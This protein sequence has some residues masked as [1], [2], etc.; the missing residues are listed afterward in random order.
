[1][2]IRGKWDHSSV[3]LVSTA[4]ASQVELRA[5]PA[6]VEVY[7]LNE[8]SDLAGEAITDL[9]GYALER[10]RGDTEFVLYRAR[11]DA[12]TRHILVLAPASE[13]PSYSTLK[14]IE[15]EYALRTELDPAWAVL[16]FAL[17]RD[18]GR[19]LLA[20]KD[21]GG[22]PLDRL[23]ERP[24]ELKQ[25]LRV[26]IALAA[27]LSRLH[28]RGI[29]HKDIKPANVMVS[30]ASDE[31]WLTGFGI[32]TDSSRE[33]QA[34][35]P[36]Q[37]IAGT[38]AYMA[39]EQTGRMNRSIDS[40]SDLY[41]LGVT[42]YQMLT[43][44]LPFTASDPVEWVYCHIARQPSPPEERRKDV[45][46]ALSAIV[47]K[48]LA[49]S[50]EERYQT[51]A[52]LQ[53]DLKRC[54][55]DLER[56]GRIEPFVTGARDVS[57]R[58]TIPEEVYGRE[59]ETTA[60]LDA[61]DRV[62][63]SGA[64]ELVLVSGHSG[65]GKSSIVNELHKAIV[66][67]RGIF[68]SGKFDQYKRDIPY[69]TLALAFQTLIRQI[70]SR[71]E[72]EVGRRRDAL[73]DAIDPNGQL[74]V[75][76][77]P[78]LELIIGKQAPVPELSAQD[79]EN[80]FQWVFRAFVGV[81][82]RKEHPLAL[83]LDDLQW[84]DAATLNLIEHLIIHPDVRHLLLIGAYR[85]NEV[86]ASHPLMLMLD[87]LRK[88][89]AAVR[90][91]VLTPL[92]ID[93]VGQLTADSVRQ[94][95]ALTEPLARLVH[96]KTAGNPFFVVQFL[97]ALAE[98]RL[99]E[100]DSRAAVWRWDVDRIRVRGIT[101]NVVDLLIGK[102]NRLPD[103]TREA[104]K[105]LACLGNRANTTTLVIV[106]GR[107]EEETHSDLKEGVREGFVVLSDGSYEFVHDRVHEAAYS[108]VPEEDRARVHLQIGRRLIAAM[109]ADK[110]AERIFN[111]VNQFNRG[112]ALISDPNEKQRVA[113]LNLL[114]ARRARASMAYA[115]AGIY[116]SAGM[117][118]LGREPWETCY[119]LAFSLWLLRAECEFLCGNFQ[120]AEGFIS[121]LLERAASKADKA[122]AYR[123]RIDLQMIKSEH[124]KAVD[125][126]LECLHLF[127]IQFSVHPTWEQVRT[128]YEKVWQ[129]LAERSIESLIDLPIM[130]DQEI[131]A[132][133]QLLSVL[134]A[135]AFFTDN[136]LLY[137]CLCYMVNLSLQYGVTDA[138]AHGFA[139]FGLILGSV[140]HRYADGYRFGKLAIDLIDKHKSVAYKSKAYFTI[141]R[142]VI[143][144]RSVA[145]ALDLI[146]AAFRAALE[147]G[148]LT[149]ACYCCA[150]M[151]THPLLRGDRLDD[152]WRESEK[153]LHF[154]RKAKFRDY[155]ERIVSQQQF[156]QCMRG[157][158]STF[159]TFSDTNFDEASF[160]AQ[161]TGDRAMVC[162][163]WILKL[164]ARF[165]SGDHEAAIAAA[166]KAKALLWTS[167]G[168]IQLLDYHYFTALV[169]AAAFEKAPQERQRE[170][171]QALSA[172]VEQL[173]EWTDN[174]PA[175]FADKHALVTAELARIDG[176]DRDA[177]RLYDQ[178][179]RSARDNGFIQ[180]EAV[181]NEVAGRFFLERGL[182][183][184]GRTYLRNARSCYLGWGARGKVKQ[185]D[186]LYQGLEEHTPPEAT[187]T[188]ATMGS[189]I[190]Q[191]DLTTVVKALQAVSR[192]IDREK[193][194]ETLMA[195]VVQHAG[196]ERG[197]LFLPRGSEYQIE[198]QATTRSN[199][200]E[201]I[202]AD[203]FAAPP[204][205]PE[206]ILNYAIRTRENVILEDASAPN[207]FSD[208]AYVLARRPRSI[209]C[210][211]LAKRRELIGVLYLENN[212]A[213]CVFTPRRLAVLELLASQAAI[214]LK[215]AQLYAD[216]RE[217][218]IERRKAEEELRQSTHALHQ[219]QEEVRQAS[220][221]AM[222]GELTASLAHELNQPLGAILSNAQAARRLLA[223]KRPN[224][225]EANAALDDVIRD[226]ARAADII[227]NIRALFQRNKVEMS[228]L[229]LRQIL[230]D[231]EHLLRSD[232]STKEISFRLDLPPSLPTVV[233]NRT[234]LIEVLI[235]LVSNAFD[236]LRESADGR[237]EVELCASQRE[238]AR[239]HI[240]VRD[241]GKGIDPETMPRLFDAF[242]T[243][244][245]K[246]MGM[247]LTIARSIIEN[248]GG[249]L[250]ATRNPDRGATLEFELPVKVSAESKN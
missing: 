68:V 108:L 77:I 55:D 5:S 40:R 73:R 83:F 37:I 192:E 164:Q 114:A 99:L 236:S 234:Q 230:L 41:S 210:L 198:A 130:T 126:A 148:D 156:I 222:M 138:S 125:T 140:F 178:A 129:T 181:A 180:N 245:P 33:R 61:F 137:V 79:A 29:I 19:T 109:P 35:T 54:L 244:K 17:V 102:L 241:S 217:E 50:A 133:M 97:T 167:T 6:N 224:V 171:R 195:S 101:D 62:V 115:G 96:E 139:Y 189:T 242:F 247:G 213:P 147:A 82:A 155:E 70:L 80:R 199:T 64:P 122:A 110:I 51:A 186:Q 36:P 56:L 15:H 75:N 146:E 168:C 183:A 187:R 185:L 177:M 90:D 23:L 144:T 197:L 215:N 120:E 151:V 20:L 67:P 219:L 157:E 243:T 143:W 4:K 134:Q 8:L 71:N 13:Q 206:A 232:A 154:V 58:L 166:Q 48:L 98:E 184:F 63:A 87:S 248:H 200:V 136:N 38:L 76:L 46:A 173:R 212:L 69:A 162:W 220:R 86:I 202:L 204:E 84:L 21:P 191:L 1:M 207:Q 190:E 142:V 149:Y 52:G 92:S 34:P 91:I 238:A 53:A 228:L 233:G 26:A 182:E 223:G 135:P 105:Q 49:K 59:R 25:F 65:I 153:C 176:R 81:F 60:L 121:E 104:L 123:L 100:F 152:V 246:G 112:V 11:S 9:S 16:P 3:D 214:S 239:V 132:V 45:P 28:E 10:L 103:N 193:L 128:E 31:V 57:D 119:A 165:I 250:W 172:H 159:S 14:R 22:Q 116:A 209:L 216:L 12:D 150:Y 74:L 161:I 106:H 169:I 78:E 7:D 39:P 145:V 111:L 72:A 226:D 221:A 237:H 42:L 141:A 47:L 27:A 170:W 240:A 175:T 44:A 203:S 113:E 160:E 218:N 30:Q 194:N 225:E 227:R 93:H 205:F 158:T 201:V 2:A 196:A 163:Y 235:N 188:T 229:D 43:S 211:P 32:A 249:R 231:V 85:D 179:I 124:T 208:D 131:Q 127:A 89:S 117:G 66:L 107:S 88:S 118:L 95:R 18:K 94:E 174:N 24:L